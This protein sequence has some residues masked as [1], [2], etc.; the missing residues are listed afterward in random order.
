[1]AALACIRNPAKPS[2]TLIF[3]TTE[4]KQV[5]YD[6]AQEKN[7]NDKF[8]KGGDGASRGANPGDENSR[9]PTLGN[10]T[11]EAPSGGLV[12]HPSAF[13]TLIFQNLIKCYGIANSNSRIIEVSPGVKPLQQ[14][15]TTTHG[16][17][18]GCGD[19]NELGWLYYISN[20]EI[21]ALKQYGLNVGSTVTVQ[22]PPTPDKDSSLTAW[23]KPT[24]SSRGVVYQNSGNTNLK[25]WETKGDGSQSNA[26]IDNTTQ[27]S[28]N[29]P[30]CTVVKGDTVYL[31][32]VNSSKSLIRVERTGSNAW[33]NQKS[34]SENEW[35]TNPI[36]AILSLDGSYIVVR[37]Q[38]T[39]GDG[40]LEYPDS[41][42][43]K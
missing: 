11:G 32:F 31:Y 4:D 6:T 2:E 37:Q 8:G 35:S 3:Y 23:Y 17:L 36:D 29:T 14:R 28:K 21:P 20:T 7:L 1:M 33:T 5:G 25:Y 27:A 39:D 10:G 15:I 12:R 40:W 16:G 42:D 26:E 22:G 9:A 18:A 38:F 30:L 41:R 19:G 34:N 43:L 13:V 24:D